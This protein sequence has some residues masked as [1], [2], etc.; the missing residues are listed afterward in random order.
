MNFETN[1]STLMLNM[2]CKRSI[3]TAVIQDCIKVWANLEIFAL[4][5]YNA[6]CNTCIY[7]NNEVSYV[8][9]LRWIN[10]LKMESNM[11]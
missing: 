6:I 1:K 4:N 9:V 10:T 11:K 2:A 8:T 3:K 5:I 7:G